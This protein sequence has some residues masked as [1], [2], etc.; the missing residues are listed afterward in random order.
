M[1]VA[2]RDKQYTPGPEKRVHSALDAVASNMR[3][4][5]PKEPKPPKPSAAEPTEP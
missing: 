3:Q 2:R 1:S 4:S 5:P